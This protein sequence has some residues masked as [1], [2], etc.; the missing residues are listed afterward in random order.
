MNKKYIPDILMCLILLIGVTYLLHENY[1]LQNIINDFEVKGCEQIRC[2]PCPECKMCIH[3]SCDTSRLEYANR[4]W[5]KCLN[6]KNDL[7]NNLTS[8][9]EELN[10]TLEKLNNI[11]CPECI[12]IQ[13]CDYG[14]EFMCS[15]YIGLLNKCNRELNS[16]SE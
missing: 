16:C 5:V 1:I 10:R 7:Q 12:A 4:Y 14:F 13:E 9:M 11:R 6:V 8:C 15:N 2:E 3:S